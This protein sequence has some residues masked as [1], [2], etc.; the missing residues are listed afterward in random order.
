M[1]PALKTDETFADML[2]RIANPPMPAFAKLEK[3]A[4]DFR[5]AQAEELA[6]DEA[7]Y[8]HRQ[9]LVSEARAAD[10]AALDGDDCEGAEA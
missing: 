10:R 4:A 5:K 6:A 8:W 1:H 3:F 2:F 7:E 9:E